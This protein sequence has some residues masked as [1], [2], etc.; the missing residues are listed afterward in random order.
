VSGYC[1]RNRSLR[2]EMLALS[3]ELL[4]HVRKRVASNEVL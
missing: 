3:N 2:V 4:T 1:A